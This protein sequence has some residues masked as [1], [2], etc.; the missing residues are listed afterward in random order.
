MI[1]D[2]HSHIGYSRVFSAGVTE[3][4]LLQTM[5][6]NAIDASL[7]M[8][9]AASDPIPTH[10]AIARLAEKRPGQIFGIISMTPLISEEA[11]EREFR[12]CVTQLGFVAVKIHPLAHAVAPNAQVCDIVFRLASEFN[13]PVM[14]HTGLGVPFALPSLIIPRARQYPDLT[15]IQ[16]HAGFAVYTAEAMIVSQECPNVYLEPSWCSAGDIKRMVSMF[17]AHKVMYGGD[18]PFNVPVEL[19]KY[20]TMG[21]T[22]EERDMCLG[23]TAINVFKLPLKVSA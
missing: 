17:G 10:D 13:I 20:R 16:A 5:E 21:L 2:V 3:E 18:L 1:V 6:A 7:V 15:I 12:R 11:Y 22:D 9:A 8:P 23:G 4:Q 14:I 19:Y